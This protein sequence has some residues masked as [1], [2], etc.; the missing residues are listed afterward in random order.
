[1]SIGKMKI[2]DWPKMGKYLYRNFILVDIFISFLLL[3][4][5]LWDDVLIAS[6]KWPINSFRLSSLSQEI[7]T[8]ILA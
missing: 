8:K 6:G 3:M 4:C 2:T 7:T 1:M 5:M